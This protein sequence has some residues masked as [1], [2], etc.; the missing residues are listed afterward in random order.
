M[1][2]VVD[3]E[4]KTVLAKESVY[5]AFP[6]AVDAPT[7]WYDRQQGCVNPAVDHLPGA[8]NDWF[9]LQHSV[10]LA[11]KDAAIAW[12]SADALLFTLDDVVRGRWATRCSPRSGTVLSWVMNNHWY[13]N[14]P[15][16]QS[17]RVRLRLRYAFHPSRTWDPAE[18]ARL[19]RELRSP[20][21][22]TA[23]RP[24][25]EAGALMRADVP[26]NVMATIL[27]PHDGPGLP[28]RLLETGGSPGSVRLGHPFGASGRA[29]RCSAVEQPLD[30][31]L[32]EADAQYAPTCA[33]SQ[34]SQCSSIQRNRVYSRPVRTRIGD[35]RPTVRVVA[36]LHE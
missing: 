5:V 34:S 31:L 19:G 21:A 23:P 3:L 7:V 13:T 25:G 2:L 8:C 36:C 4:K 33:P 1:D 18:A 32:V 35:R 20:V 16:S 27:H 24:L 14:Y 30:S 29:T 15:A 22:G 6:F 9:A 17:G 12:S 11:A 10:G 26:Q 28:M